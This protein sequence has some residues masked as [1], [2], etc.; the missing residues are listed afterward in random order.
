MA[1][2]EIPS[3]TIGTGRVDGSRHTGESRAANARELVLVTAPPTA[4]VAIDAAIGSDRT[5]LPG[6]AAI[7]QGPLP[8]VGLV[9]SLGLLWHFTARRSA[10]WPTSASSAPTAGHEPS[11]SR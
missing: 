11:S 4:A 2:D 6:G 5:D 7:V 10:D 9:L 8:F 1:T 3:T